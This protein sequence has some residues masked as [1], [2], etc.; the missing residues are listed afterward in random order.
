MANAEPEVS[1]KF[2]YYSIYPVSVSDLGRAMDAATPIHEEG[3]TFRGHTH[4]Y[5]NW[6]FWW[7]QREGRCTI[8][9][10][11]ATVDI[12]YIMPQLTSSVNAETRAAFQR[13]DDALITHEK[14]HARHGIDAA[15]EVE[16]K[17]MGI[18]SAINCQIT[19]SIAN[20]TGKQILQKYN[21]Q[22]VVY[23]RET[24]HGRTQGAFLP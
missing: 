3:R 20:D 18:S 19:E 7:D 12:Q 9:R 16:N 13:Y 11:Q 21:Q 24:N 1:E 14:G 15:R 5:V 17:L 10:V 23:D 22:D 6:H 8:N 4:W 2:D